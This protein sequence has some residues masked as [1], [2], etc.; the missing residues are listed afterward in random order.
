[1][2]KQKKLKVSLHNVIRI[3]LLTTQFS[4]S[5]QSAAQLEKPSK[6]ELGAWDREC[7]AQGVPRGG[8]GAR[9]DKDY[10]ILRFG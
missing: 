9:E 10:R 3:H 7:Q 8:G 6:E 2:K 5:K 1:M 4:E